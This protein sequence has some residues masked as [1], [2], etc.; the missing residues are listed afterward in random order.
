MTT[1]AYFNTAARAIDYAMKDA[2]LIGEGETPTSEQY[3]ENLNRLNDIINLEQT[4]GIKLWTLQDTS[5]TLTVGQGTYTFGPAGTT[6]MAKPMRVVDAYYSDVNGVRRP[7]IPMAWADYV[8][9]SQINQVGAINSYFV[10]KQATQLSVFFWMLPDT[11]TA[12]GTA[13][14]VL[15]TQVTNMAQV[16]DTTAFPLEWFLFIR[17]ALADEICTG[18]PQAIMD[19]CQR[20]CEMYRQMLED[21]D[22][23]DTST[24]FTPDSQT[25]LH[26]GGFQ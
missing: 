20:R 12:T 7:L 5:I 16:T 9:L 11:T 4:Q 22:V 25:F 19:R 18:Q 14:L 3:A 8:R 26:G 24:R 21:W 10:N 6:V 1:P 23:E 2:G 17:W 13:H 15:Q